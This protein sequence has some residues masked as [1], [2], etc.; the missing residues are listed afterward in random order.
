MPP[1]PGL[2]KIEARSHGLLS[3]SGAVACVAEKAAVRKTTPE[4]TPGNMSGN[5]T[6][7]IVRLPTGTDETTVTPESIAPA[8][9]VE[10]IAQPAKLRR[11]R[12]GWEPSRIEAFWFEGDAP[13]LSPRDL[14]LSLIV[15]GGTSSTTADPSLL[16]IPSGAI[17]SQAPALVSAR[18][19]GT[20]AVRALYPGGQSKPVQLEFLNASPRRLGFAGT[21]KSF[22]GLASGSTELW[23]RLLDD[24]DEPAITEKPVAVDVAVAGPTGTRSYSA[25]IAAGAMQAKVALELNRP[26]SYTIQ[27]SAPG[28]RESD[29]LPV[30]FAVDWL[31]LSM[32][33]LGGLLGSLTRVLYRRNRRERVWPKG[34]LRVLVLG[35]AAA[36]LVLLL[37]LFGLLSL[38]SG[39]LPEGVSA[40][41]QKVSATSLFGV[42][43]LGYLGGLLFDKVLG[44]F[45]GGGGGGKAAPR[46]KAATA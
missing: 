6:A 1:K 40:E 10:L 27:A 23:V 7:M 3:G 39:A 8:G 26:G 42:L 2:W 21:P 11:V 44:R 36:L 15:D 24:N 9:R 30:R 38:L 17:K 20:A 37:S 41:L 25:N 35:V 12:G 13:G 22:R 29:A 31:L 4:K 46:V 43:L 18:D 16:S 32:A 33:L 45:L 19:A 34:I 5:L 14:S 28:L